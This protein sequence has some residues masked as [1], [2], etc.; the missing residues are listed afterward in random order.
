MR[1]DIIKK[2]RLFKYKIQYTQCFLQKKKCK[3]M[4]VGNIYEINRQLFLMRE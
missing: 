3:T 4:I 1:F 2:M